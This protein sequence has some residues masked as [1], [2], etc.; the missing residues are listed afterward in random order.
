MGAHILCLFAGEAHQLFTLHSDLQAPATKV[1]L[2][3]Q[4]YEQQVCW[5]QGADPTIVE[6]WGMY[7]YDGRVSSHDEAMDQDVPDDGEEIAH[8]DGEW[9]KLAQ[10]YLF[11]RQSRMKVSWTLASVR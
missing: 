8:A 2:E 7:L 10:A 4:F 6:L 3:T 1:Y 9:S 5:L 11:G